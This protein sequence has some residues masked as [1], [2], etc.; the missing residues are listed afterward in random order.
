MSVA[1]IRRQHAAREQTRQDKAWELFVQGEAA[2]AKGRTGAARIFYQMAQRRGD[3]ELRQRCA[4]RL[5]ALPPT[6]DTAE[7]AR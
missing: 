5:S 2:E 1:E 7:K 4:A 3:A 6:A